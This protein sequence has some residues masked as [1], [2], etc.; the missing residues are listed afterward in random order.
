MFIFEEK[1][2][3][4]EPKEKTTDNCL[5]NVVYYGDELFA[6]TETLFTRRIDPV[7][8]KTIGKKTRLTDYVA[9]N[10]ATAHPHVLEDGSVL[11]IG[12]NYRHKNGPHYCV[13]KIP[14][15]YNT[16]G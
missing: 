8:L 5:I 3:K 4:D 12:S 7:T 10:Q 6:M 1:E 15:T 2:K 13:I 16:N 11:N 9:V 14:P